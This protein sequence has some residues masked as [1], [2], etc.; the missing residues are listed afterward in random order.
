MSA[1]ELEPFA[2][3]NNEAEGDT[4]PVIRIRTVLKVTARPHCGVARCSESSCI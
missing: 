1:R 4:F 2:N 3:K